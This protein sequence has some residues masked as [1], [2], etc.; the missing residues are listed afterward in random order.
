MAHPAGKPLGPRSFDELWEA[1][2]QV[3]EGFVGEI[4]DGGIVEVQRPDYPHVAATS[5]LGILLGGWFRFGVG[6]PGGWVILD[7]PKLPL[8]AKHY[9]R[10]GTSWMLVAAHGGAAKVRAEP[11]DAVELDLSMIWGPTRA[12]PQP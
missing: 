4:V 3:R 1:L 8:D 5:D 10:E 2:L 6:G 11:F 9:R 7:E 12:P